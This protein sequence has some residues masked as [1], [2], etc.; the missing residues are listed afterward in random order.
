MRGNRTPRPFVPQARDLHLLREAVVLKVFDRQQAQLCAGFT[1]NTRSHTRIS[2]LVD[3]DLLRSFYTASE[4]GGKKDGPPPAEGGGRPGLRLAVCSGNFALVKDRRGLP[5]EFSN[6]CVF[7]FSFRCHFL[8]YTNPVRSLQSA[9]LV[10]EHRILK[11]K[12][13]M[14][15]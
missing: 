9:N 10:P 2:K 8:E 13:V 4:A 5:Q 14:R 1:S 6:F 3:E 12:I 11:L 7:P 15:S